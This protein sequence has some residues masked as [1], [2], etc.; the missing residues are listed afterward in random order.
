MTTKRKIYQYSVPLILGFIVF[1]MNNIHSFANQDTPYWSGAK[2]EENGM[3]TWKLSISKDG[4]S[5]KLF[6]AH[7]TI[8][9]ALWG[10]DCEGK[11]DKIG[12]LFD[13]KC[14]LL[15]KAEL[16]IGGSVKK[17]IYSIGTSPRYKNMVWEV[18]GIEKKYSVENQNI[19]KKLGWY[20]KGID[21][22][23]Q[24]SSETYRLRF[25]ADGKTFDFSFTIYLINSNDI[26]KCNGLVDQ[27]GNFYDY[28]CTSSGM[29]FVK[30]IWDKSSVNKIAFGINNERYGIRVFFGLQRKYRKQNKS[31]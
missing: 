1:F 5:F 17:I 20:W 26:V 13:V 28:S 31:S 2:V 10:T 27:E 30:L 16:S 23:Y 24:D 22:E 9:Y 6:Y 19:T 4:K 3:G 29:A 18:K 15:G 8:S 7:T 12:N 14:G 11:I 21:T 25:S